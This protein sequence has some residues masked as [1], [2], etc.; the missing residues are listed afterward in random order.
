MYLKQ[1]GLIFFEGLIGVSICLGDE[2][3]SKNGWILC[4]YKLLIAQR[5][6]VAYCPKNNLEMKGAG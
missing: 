5:Y 4:R 2:H 6:L 3:T 1:S